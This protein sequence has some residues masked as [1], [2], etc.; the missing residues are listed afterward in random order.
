MD[1]AAVDKLIVSPSAEDRR[2]AAGVL[3]E[4]P[5][6][7]AI[8]RLTRLIDDPSRA[9]VDAAAAALELKGG[10]EAVELIAPLIASAN[11][12]VRN[13]AIELLRK[14]GIDGLDILHD[15]A[16]S[17]QDNDRLFSVDILGTIAS[18]DSLECLTQSLK[19]SNSNVRNAAAIALGQL[20]DERAL[21]SL[22]PLLDD[23]EWIRFSAI[24]AL[25]KIPEPAVTDF[26]VAELDRWHDDDLT[27]I[28]IMEALRNMPSATII[29][30]LFKLIQRSN[31]YVQIEIAKAL[32]SVMDDTSLA[33][34]DKE[35]SLKLRTILSDHLLDEE[36]PEQLIMTLALGLLG[37]TA[38]VSVLA[39]LAG[40][41][42][43]DA[44]L[45]ETI[46]QAL[47]RI[48]APEATLELLDRGDKFAVMAAEVLSESASPEV[49]EIIAAKI[50]SVPLESKRALAMALARNCTPETR[51][52]LLKLAADQDG[53][54]ISYALIGL[55][56]V[57]T[58][59]DIDLIAS[60]L[61]HPY[62]DVRQNALNAV[63]GVKTPRAESVIMDLIEDDQA[64]IRLLALEG[65]QKIDSQQFQ[66]QL[67]CLFDDEC[68]DVRLGAYR[69]AHEHKIPLNNDRL[70]KALDDPSSKIRQLAIDIIGQEQLIHFRPLIEKLI[71]DPDIWTAHRAAEALGHFR[72]EGARSILLKILKGNGDFIKIAALDIL[73][74][75]DDESLSEEIEILTEDPNPDIAR[76]AS[77]AIKRLRKL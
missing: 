25:G 27:L 64:E 51:S 53:H 76:A 2:T 9:V 33:S 14:I 18:S 61:K 31:P 77:R 60:L 3:S 11:P 57:G 12:A 40:M 71:E 59:D 6:R 69:L 63:I 54:I 72:D 22:K 41:T 15:L 19:D 32:I 35:R 66:S 30:P 73:A 10:R 16:R 34:L 48:N 28:A 20:G 23:E 4:M 38:T 39:E 24:E 29:E 67:V 7:E 45:W 44:P 56:K 36:A 8:T 58:P 46:I 70:Q 65:L 50:E 62:P 13:V 42:D 21:P 26:L 5:G 52:H 55:A 43:P 1:L 68:Q 47:K 74:Q 37:D 49:N 75:W 17:P